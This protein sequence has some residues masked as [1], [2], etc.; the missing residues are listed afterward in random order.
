MERAARHKVVRFTAILNAETMFPFGL[1]LKKCQTLED[2]GK[3]FE[4]KLTRLN[5][6]LV[7]RNGC[8]DDK[9]RCQQLLTSLASSL[10]ELQTILVVMRAE[11]SQR[12]RALENV[13][14]S[15]MIRIYSKD[16]VIWT[17]NTLTFCPN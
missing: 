4:E 5:Q 16:R 9:E 10:S 7:L 3:H 2:L 12:K 11:L 15:N 1:Q 17:K 8:D 13:N 14:V 6:T